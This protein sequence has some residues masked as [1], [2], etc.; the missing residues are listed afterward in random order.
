MEVAVSNV[1]AAAPACKPPEPYD[2][3]PLFPHARNR[4]AD[5]IR[6]K[7]WYLGTSSNGSEA[8]LQHYLAHRNALQVGFRPQPSVF[9]SRS[10]L[11][12]SC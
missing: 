2:D 8:M 3:F 10:T 4:W 7:L 1:N 5:K 6:G 12:F 11:L 9:L